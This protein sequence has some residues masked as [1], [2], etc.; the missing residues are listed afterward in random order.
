MRSTS[1]SGLL[2]LKTITGVVSL[3]TEGDSNRPSKVIK[4]Q[5]SDVQAMIRDAERRFRGHS[6]GVGVHSFVRVLNGETRDFCGTVVAIGNGRAVV[7]IRLKTRS[8]MLETPLA[9]LLNLSYVP[10]DLRTYYHCPLVRG[11]GDPDRGLPAAYAAIDREIEEALSHGLT[12]EEHALL[13]GE[14]NARK[15]EAAKAA[16]DT[17]EALEL[18]RGDTRLEEAPAS[19]KRPAAPPKRSRQKTVTALVRKLILID[20]IHI[21]MGVATRVVAAIRARGGQ[22]A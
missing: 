2:R 15:A 5:D 13:G 14:A 17:A 22:A 21:P 16:E 11:L 3:V 1:F 18:V 12:P 20:H 4:V 7:R 19:Q 6:S 10:P 8:I 9:N